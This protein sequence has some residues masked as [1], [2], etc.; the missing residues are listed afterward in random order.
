M[1]PAAYLFVPIFLPLPE[2]SVSGHGTLSSTGLTAERDTFKAE[3]DKLK[4]E[5]NRLDGTL[6]HFQK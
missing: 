6:E 1:L 5:V 2:V 3:R 4:A